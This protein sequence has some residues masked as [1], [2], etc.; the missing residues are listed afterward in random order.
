MI[1]TAMMKKVHSLGKI[2]RGRSQRTVEKS[3]TVEWVENNRHMLTPRDIAM[4]H[5][6][7]QFP[8]MTIEHLVQLTPETYNR[9][10]SIIEPFHTASNGHRLCRDRIRRLYDLHFVDKFSPRLPHG[11]G[12]APQYIWLD[13]ASYRLFGL[14]G[15]PLKK[16]SMEYNHHKQILDV[17][18]LFKQLEREGVIQIDYLSSCYATKPKTTNIIPDLIVCFKKGAYGYKYLIEVD[19][20][21]KKESDELKK[22]ARYRDWELSSQWIK[23]DWADFYKKRF[24]VVMYICSGEPSRVNRRMTVL[25]K[26]ARIENAHTVCL[27]IE[28]TRQRLMTLPS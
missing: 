5:L 14:T 10:D 17:Y 3:I 24:P 18:C 26:S 22:L 9:N 2:R 6:L 23:E 7:R 8:V 13:R 21:E 1:Q 11:E 12:T 4:L 20:G 27:K 25:S 16:L 19:T 28:D 15:H